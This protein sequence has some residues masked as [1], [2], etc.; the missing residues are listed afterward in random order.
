MSSPGTNLRKV[1]EKRLRALLPED[2]PVI[3]VGTAETRRDLEGDIAEAGRWTFLVVTEHRVVHA[4]WGRHSAPHEE[5]VFDDVATWADGHQ[6]HRYAMTIEH[7]PLPRL[8]RGPAHQFLWFRWG[9]KLVEHNRGETN[10]VFS[11][12]DTAAAKALR[13]ALLSLERPH[14]SLELEE[15]TRAERTAGSHIAHFSKK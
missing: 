13:N 5:I 12:S 7:P 1:C 10:L 11:H 14:G 8:E 4:D 9:R 2:E 15:R 3:A 6:Y